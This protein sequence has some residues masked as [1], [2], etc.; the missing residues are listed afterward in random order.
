MPKIAKGWLVTIDPRKLETTGSASKKVLRSSKVSYANIV[1]KYGE[2]IS[3]PAPKDARRRRLVESSGDSPI[4]AFLTDEQIKNFAHDF[5]K[6]VISKMENGEAELIGSAKQQSPSPAPSFLTPQE[7]AKYSKEYS[8]TTGVLPPA[9]VPPSYIEEMSKVS[10]STDETDASSGNGIYDVEPEGGRGV[11][12]YVIDTGI[13]NDAGEFGNRIAKGINV[14]PVGSP[15]NVD[16][17]SGHGSWVASKIAGNNYGIARSVTI[18]PVKVFD[19]SIASD[20]ATVIRG[21]A[22]A[23]ENERQYLADHP[24]EPPALINMSFKFPLA[25]QDIVRDLARQANELGMIGFSAAGNDRVDAC[26]ILPAAWSAEFENM[27]TIGATAADGTMW[28]SSNFN[29]PA[30][31]VQCV[32]YWQRGSYVL[33]Y[34]GM[35]SGTSMATPHAVGLCAILRG[36]YPKAT[37]KQLLKRLADQSVAIKVAADPDCADIPESPPKRMIKEQQRA[38]LREVDPATRPLNAPTQ[39]TFE[40]LQAGQ[41]VA[42]SFTVKRNNPSS[43]SPLL[44]AAISSELPL[45]FES[46]QEAAA[47]CRDPYFNGRAIS[48]GEFAGNGQYWIRLN[49][50]LSKDGVERH[51]LEVGSGDVIGANIINTYNLDTKTPDSGL[52]PIV[53]ATPIQRLAFHSDEEMK[54]TD[55]KLEGFKTWDPQHTYSPIMSTLAPTAA[56]TRKAIS[57]AVVQKLSA[58]KCYYSQFIPQAG[59][60]EMTIQIGTGNFNTIK[61][62]IEPGRIVSDSYQAFLIPGLKEG[63]PIR[64]KIAH[65]GKELQISVITSSG[66]KLIDSWKSG[67]INKKIPVEVGFPNAVT[68]YIEYAKIQACSL[69]PP[70]VKAAK[71]RTA[72]RI[73]E[74]AEPSMLFSSAKPISGVSNTALPSFSN[75]SAGGWAASMLTAGATIASVAM[76]FGALGYVIYQKYK[77]EAQEG[78]VETVAADEKDQAEIEENLISA[79]QAEEAIQK[80]RKS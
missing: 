13:V 36:K 71:K 58:G 17:H 54:L 33:A 73:L 29:K 1:E 24:G 20:V 12:V 45:G 42:M 64:F 41:S 47:Q 3:A 76:A 2:V 23:I 70:S 16:D 52:K 6:A 19:P 25:Y 49:K 65:T 56:P 66:V 68:Q 21:I 5:P 62:T 44:I 26:S 57:P 53:G 11:R 78:Q 28:G 18:I 30:P 43:H 72:G 10:I 8:S 67:S 9:T 51:I 27:L 22:W 55:F 59:K 61:F 69:K 50:R 31:A 60:K 77:G 15:D 63:S 14:T 48:L 74:S 35:K 80:P 40:P 4:I 7:F 39:L 46:Y 75:D 38:E 37:T 79:I 32:G 34:G